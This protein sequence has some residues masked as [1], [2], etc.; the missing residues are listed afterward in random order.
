MTGYENMCN[1]QEF[2]KWKNKNPKKFKAIQDR[3]NKKLIIRIIDKHDEDL[4]ND[5]ERLSKEFI[6]ENIKILKD[7]L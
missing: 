1:Y 2:L 7:E 6:L 5:N 3:Y 4:K